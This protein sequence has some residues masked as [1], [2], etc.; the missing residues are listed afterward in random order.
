M[1]GLNYVATVKRSK[2]TLIVD[3][4]GNTVATHGDFHFEEVELDKDSHRHT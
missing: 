1:F 3:P 4:V 2:E